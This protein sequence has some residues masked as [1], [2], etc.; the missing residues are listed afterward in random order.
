MASETKNPPVEANAP[1]EERRVELLATE[2]GL[3]LV[4]IEQEMREANTDGKA[5][6]KATNSNTFQKL[7]KD[8]LKATQ[9]AWFIY[10][11]RVE[12]I[13]LDPIE[14]YYQPSQWRGIAV[15]TGLMKANLQIAPD[16]L[17]DWIAQFKRDTKRRLDSRGRLKVRLGI[18]PIRAMIQMLKRKTKKEP[19]SE[20]VLRRLKAM[21]DWKEMNG[22]EHFSGANFNPVRKKIEGILAEASDTPPPVEPYKELSGDEFGNS[23]KED[24]KSLAPDEALKWH[25]LMNLAASVSGSKPTKKFLAEAEALKDEL[26][27][28][29]VRDLLQDWIGRAV[30]A[31]MLEI[32]NTYE[33]SG[34]IHG[35]TE[36]VVFTQSNATLL[37]GLVWICDQYQDSKT[38]NL[39]ADLCERSMKKI[40]GIGPVARATATACLWYLEVTP[41]TEATV[42]L[43]RLS[44]AIKQKSVQKRVAQIVEKKAEAAGITTIQ[45]EE[46]AVPTYGLTEGEKTVA[47]DDYALSIVV[48]GPGQVAQTWLKPDGTSQKTKPKFVSEKEMHKERFDE[49]K[50]DVT[51]LKK[52]LTAQ[53]DRIDGLFV[54]DI[55]WPLMDVETYY[56]GHDLVGVIA[57][58]LIWS[59]TTKGETTGAI[60]RDGH[61]ETVNGD[62]V[63]TSAGT[64]ARLWHPI[65]WEIDEVMG[66]RARLAEL[67]IV[68]PTKQAYREVYL[69]TDAE[70]STRVYSNRMAA[71][72][73]KQ[74]QMATLMATRGWRYQLMG[75]YDNGIDNQWASRNYV[76]SDLT[77]EYLL[78]TNCDGDNF[79]DA[80]IYLYVGTDQLRFTR[81][82]EAVELETVDARLLSETMREADLFVGVA[83]VGND[84]LWADQGPTPEARD[85]WQGYSFG[86]LDNFAETRK[87]VL[88]TLI[89]RLKIRDVAHIDGKFLIVEGKLNTYKIHLG[90]SNVLMAPGDRYLCIVP[91]SVS[92]AGQVALPFE[93][94]NRLSVI[95][96]KAMM[97]AKDDK[98]TANDIASQLKR[99]LKPD[100]AG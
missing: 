64:K 19:L 35:S 45:L 63:G 77:A 86:N 53:R 70:R 57:S 25:R 11:N 47:F 61:W 74:H 91:G 100:I 12:L 15:F 90:S 93:G 97:L 82:D 58:K 49:L 28:E 14:A 50:A 94:D 81:N 83:S 9:M 13:G 56:V 78:H 66:W 38:V 30:A 54:E 37:K 24:R 92:K 33:F 23:L 69:L 27:K 51:V 40:P 31:K 89:P 29:W 88:E 46:R 34:R 1:T 65:D 44:T 68:Q 18:W 39:I 84:P 73:L 48:D 22:S 10:E 52:V 26:G 42:R 41:G 17:L 8:V 21:L 36:F 98:I 80:G 72:M 62:M 85:Y 4:K 16:D 59:L 75:S 55:E 7:K 2:P 76:T 95:L 96:S 79:N 5:G 20:D 71:H 67:E 6:L 43:S 3:L 32:D 87:Q 99:G 60:W